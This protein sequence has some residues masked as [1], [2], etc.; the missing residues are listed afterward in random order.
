MCIAQFLDS[1]LNPF[2]K[3]KRCDRCFNRRIFGRTIICALTFPRRLISAETMI[4]LDKCMDM[5][6][7]IQLE[8]RQSICSACGP[9][10]ICTVLGYF[11][12]IHCYTEWQD[13][14]STQAPTLDDFLAAPALPYTLTA[15][16]LNGGGEDGRWKCK[17]NST[18]WHQSLSCSTEKDRKSMV[19]R[20]RKAC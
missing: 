1:P 3:N 2:A 14:V 16:R 13:L 8:K 11:W 18:S 17:K 12:K 6:E 20:H 7:K 19:K 5:K 9:C 10:C 4:N 15:G